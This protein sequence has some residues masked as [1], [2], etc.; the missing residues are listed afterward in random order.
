MD[1]LESNAKQLKGNDM[2]RGTGATTQ[3]MQDAP[4]GAVF[5]WCNNRLEYPRALARKIGRDDLSIVS[6]YWLERGWA[7][8][9]FTDLVVDHACSLSAGEQNGL[10]Y[11]ITRLRS[12]NQGNRRA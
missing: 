10:K 11:A 1:G 12:N 7:G 2:D 3:Q 4:K 6:P 9:K 5:V 8:Q